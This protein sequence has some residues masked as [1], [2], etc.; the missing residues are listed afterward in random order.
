MLLPIGLQDGGV[1][2]L[3]WACI[4]LAVLSVAILAATE[5]SSREVRERT[6]ALEEM[7]R[8]WEA[9]P[10]LDPEEEFAARYVNP[11]IRGEM[12]QARQ[13]AEQMRLIP[14]ELERQRQQKRFDQLC[15]RFAETDADPVTDDWAL[16][17]RRGFWQL[18]LL[19]YIFLHGGWVHLLGNFFFLYLVGP[20]LEDV[21][22]RPVFVGFYLLGG[23]V[24]GLSQAA[25]DASSAIPIVGASGAVAACMGAFALR[26]ATRK[27]RMLYWFGIV[28]GTFSIP[29]WVWAILWFGREVMDFRL[30]GTSAGV[31]FMSHIGGFVFGFGV[32]ALFR[33]SHIEELYITPKLNKK[34]D[35]YAQHPEVERASEALARGNRAAARN[36]FR[37]ALEDDPSN[38]D[39]SCGLARLHLDDG[40]ATSAS[41]ALD[42]A[43]TRVLADKDGHT[44]PAMLDEFGDKLVHSALRP[45]T[46][47]RLGQAIEA[48][49]PS[50]A[51]ACYGAA[52]SG[53]GALGAKALLKAATMGLQVLHRPSDA[54]QFALRAQA[55][56]HLPPALQS[57]AEQIVAAATQNAAATYP[58]LGV[59]VPDLELDLPESETA[60][61]LP[62]E[63]LPPLI[64]S[65]QFVQRLQDGLAV[66]SADGQRMRLSP[67]AVTSVGLGIVESLGPAQ[68]NV[69]VLDVRIDDPQT[70]GAQIFR[71]SSHQLGLGRLFP[72]G[73][74]SQQAFHSLLQELIEPAGAT[75]VPAPD[76]VATGRYPRFADLQAFEQAC[77]GRVWS[78]SG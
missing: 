78:H 3:P 63:A 61:E 64:H 77:Y 6:R 17:P 11:Q 14:H 76:I 66:Q 53:P 51:M 49:Y 13:R 48:N 27:I 31:A 35:L 41:S 1:N 72:A 9:H 30:Y 18:G 4:T 73:T 8:Y 44:L 36:A 21:W 57:Q 52:G 43:L 26:F 19:G 22:G 42:A 65:T 70:G 71:F 37:K 2:R 39:A 28:A 60:S 74:P 15:E 45:A 10:Y 68:R 67:A 56:G 24:A 50:W 25:L 38:Y 69:L 20:F 40:D 23:A 58:V 5:P 59:E 32:A 29:A 62:A 47:F 16:V 54:H 12:D 75:V 46:A 33:L 34:I 55:S 7:A